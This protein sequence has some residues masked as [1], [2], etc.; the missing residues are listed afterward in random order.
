MT[1]NVVDL[2]QQYRHCFTGGAYEA[3]SAKVP[4]LRA[5]HRLAVSDEGAVYTRTQVVFAS[6]LASSAD[7]F[8]WAARSL[9][10]FCNTLHQERLLMGAL[11]PLSMLKL[12]NDDVVVLV[13]P[14]VPEN[15]VEKL[16]SEYH[17]LTEEGEHG[18]A[19]RDCVAQKFPQNINIERLHAL[20]AALEKGTYEQASALL[21]PPL[22]IE[23]IPDA[24]LSPEF[25][26]QALRRPHCQC[27]AATSG[28]KPY[29]VGH[30]DYCPVKAVKA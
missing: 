29:A 25:L 27:G 9:A 16:K 11:A 2:M 4:S 5:N 6:Y 1:L 21:G 3:L 30:A 20:V 15:A 12:Q 26:E 8:G 14:H 19:V 10:E 7:E 23:P 13:F 24:V 22:V 17:F 28:Y 18:P